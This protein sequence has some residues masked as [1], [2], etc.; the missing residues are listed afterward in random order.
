[1]SIPQPERFANDICWDGFAGP[2]MT[3]KDAPLAGVFGAAGEIM[4]E[5]A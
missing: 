5:L 3:T 1:M 2:A 4:G